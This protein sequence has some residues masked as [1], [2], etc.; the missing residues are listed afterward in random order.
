MEKKLLRREPVTPAFEYS[1]LH[2]MLAQVY[3]ARGVSSRDELDLSLKQLPHPRLLLNAERAADVLA[4]AIADQQ[5]IVIV[6]DFDADGATSSALAMIALRQMGAEKLSYLV[7]NRFEDGYGLTPGLVSEALKRAPDVIVTVDNGIASVD[8]IAAAR[9]AGLTTI[10]TDHHLPGEVLPQAD[11]IVN[12][13][14]PGCTF[15]GRALAGVG[16]IFYVMMALRA[17]LREQHWFNQR[18]LPEPALAQ[19]LDL[20]ALGTVADVV[21]LDHC[22]RIFVDAGL[23]RMRAGQARPGIM[24][25]LQVAGRA[26]ERLVA[27]DLG[28]TVGPRLN[29]AGRLDDMSVG[30]ECLLAPTADTAMVLA[31]QLNQLNQ[32]RR[33]IEQGMRDQAMAQLE[34]LALDD[35]ETPPAAV[36]LYKE[37][38]HQG[39]IG[40]LASRVKETLHRPVIA[41]ADGDEGQIKGS[42]RSI[43]GIHIRDVLAAVDAHQPGLLL[44]FGGH[45]MAAGMT[46]AR[47]DYEAF[48]EAF[49]AEVERCSETVELQATVLSDGEIPPQDMT[50]ELAG[51][52]RFA[53][54]WGQQFPEPIFDGE[55]I[56]VQQRLVGERHL[57]LVLAPPQNP[58]QSIDA[59][60][61]NI[62][63][64]QWPNNNVERVQVAYRLDVNEF[65]GRRTVQLMVEHIQDCSGD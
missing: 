24:A 42:G 27:S 25:L 10:V 54:P 49:V 56:L 36:T 65:R 11:V 57:K 59:I 51:L 5:H 53:G 30:I 41:F 37:D 14:Q 60:A 39:V 15:P 48:S 47:R 6:G 52:L 17:A 4:K 1:D 7:P 50:L 13:H 26:H 55:F 33:S 29:A 3:A 38:W 31:Q 23:K 2:P 62:D 35:M 12:P 8:G 46:L 61:F 28:F 43:S 21:P 16:V 20:V 19:L 44:K 40:I 18:Q 58:Q 64:E 34:A 63:T 9:E 32:D 45:A 22:N